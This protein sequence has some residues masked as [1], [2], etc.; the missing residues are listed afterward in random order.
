MKAA[1][2]VVLTD[3]Y[4]YF[5]FDSVDEN[6]IPLESQSQGS[7][8]VIPAEPER[9]KGKGK[10]HSESLI[11]AKKWKKIAT[12][13]SRKL[14]NSASIP[15]KPTLTP[16][17]GKITIINPVVTSKGKSPKAVDNKFG[18]GKFKGKYPKRIKLLTA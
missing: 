15:G 7:T 2:E 13:R 11:L 6:F 3:I 18:K 16:S 10:T 1:F 17:T 8:P 4:P 9:S 5:L 12:Q 14:Q